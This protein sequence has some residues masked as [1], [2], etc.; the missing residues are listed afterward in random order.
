MG[1]ILM[2]NR[3]HQEQ[4][5]HVRKSYVNDAIAVLRSVRQPLRLADLAQ[6]ISQHRNAE[7]S[8]ASLKSCLCR[9]L[10]TE[11]ANGPLVR[12]SH[13]VFA[14]QEWRAEAR[15]ES[16]SNSLATLSLR[17]L[18]WALAQSRPAVSPTPPE[19]PNLEVVEMYVWSVPEDTYHGIRAQRLYRRVAD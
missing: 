7:V 11:G 19:F 8:L 10:Q 16:G 6:R 1:N 2:E 5:A 4:H 17:R 18:V 13:G 12:V 3:S 14:L 9:Y 15:A